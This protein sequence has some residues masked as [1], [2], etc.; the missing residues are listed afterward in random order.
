MLQTVWDRTHK[1][2]HRLLMKTYMLVN[3]FKCSGRTH[4]EVT[5][6]AVSKERWEGDCFGGTQEASTLTGMF[7][8]FD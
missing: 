1:S 6:V 7:Y 5:T 3:A 2:V 8:F 4:A